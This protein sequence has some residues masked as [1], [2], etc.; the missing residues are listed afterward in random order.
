M[1]KRTVKICIGDIVTDA[2]LYYSDQ[3]VRLVYPNT[4]VC[5]DD[6]I[7]FIALQKLRLTLEAS[8]I[9]ILVNGSRKDVYPS[10][11]QM[12]MGTTSAYTLIMGQG[13]RQIVDIFDDCLDREL[14]STVHL[15]EQFHEDWLNAL[16]K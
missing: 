2:R 5:E 7:P 15:Q 11:M 6:A 8:G 12:N 1:I 3:T 14:I 16:L 10:G 9:F 13:A 4:E